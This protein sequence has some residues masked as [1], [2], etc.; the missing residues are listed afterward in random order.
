[1]SSKN[2]KRSVSLAIRILIGLVLGVIV[3]IALQGNPEIATTYI[4]PIGTV[5]L[6][7]IKLIIVP[8]VFASLVVG[9]AGME[10]VT[11]L[12]RVGAKTFIYYFI[13]TAIA[14][15]IGLLLANVLNVGGGYVLPSA[16]DITYEAAEAPPFIQTLV[17]IIPSNPL[18]SIVNGDMLQIIVFAL[19]F[20]VGLLVIGEKGKI[21]FSI[22][23]SIAEAMYAITR[24]IMSLAPIG[25]FGLIAPVIAQNGPE[26]LLPLL[27]L[28]A[29]VYLASIV[30]IIVVY[31]L[32]VKFLSG[33]NPIEFAKKAFPAW[34][35]AF[36][37][38]SSSGTL[39]VTMQCAETLGVPQPIS[40]FV[41]PLGAT[42][43]M[44]GTAIYQGVSALFIAQVFGVNLSISQQLTIIL[45][46]TL[47]SV[48]T[49]GV[50][51]AGMIMLAMV[52]QSVGLPVEGIALVAGVDRILD[53]MR[54]SLN[55]LGDLT[56]STFVTK[57][58][59]DFVYV[60]DNDIKDPDI[61]L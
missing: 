55:V 53:M 8:L 20:G 38:S 40:S 42:I 49:A 37:T 2:E 43:N 59:G 33:I 22:F 3:G 28:I 56:A 25:V 5:F 30:H 54:T 32:S 9:V 58:E 48:G 46:A 50:P 21:V 39:P 13:T 45:T 6:N 19:I 36:T 41:L 31:G 60:V 35:T 57:T 16:A 26:V 61:E 12:G 15:F 29:I 11:K 24:F 18:K 1:M 4:A 52:L 7:L 23:D 34:A 47:A 10:D 27:K 17:N 14:I 51:G 44:D